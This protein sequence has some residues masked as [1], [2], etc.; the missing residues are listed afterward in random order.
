[1]K[2]YYLSPS[3]LDTANVEIYFDEDIGK[4]NGFY[5]VDFLFTDE[6]T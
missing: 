6:N 4:V 5:W 1:M 3:G 2:T